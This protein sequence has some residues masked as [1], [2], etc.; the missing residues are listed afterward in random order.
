VNIDSLRTWI[1][2]N[3]AVVLLAAG[4][5]CPSYRVVLV[6]KEEGTKYRDFS[7]AATLGQTSVEQER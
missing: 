2:D 7:K 1:N 5:T 3:K 4:G 6:L